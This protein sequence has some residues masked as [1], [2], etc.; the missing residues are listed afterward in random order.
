MIHILLKIMAGQLQCVL[1]GMVL[2]H[3]DNGIMILIYKIIII[4]L[5][6][7]IYLLII[8]KFHLN[9]IIIHNYKIKMDVLWPCC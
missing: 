5:L 6:Q 3:Q 8:L 1:L 9:G 2:F 4:I 7:C